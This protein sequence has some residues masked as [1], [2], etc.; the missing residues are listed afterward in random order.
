MNR[1]LIGSALLVMLTA[2]NE[3]L[4]LII[5]LVGAVAFIGKIIEARERS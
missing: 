2:Q 4:S 3:I 1:L 5:L